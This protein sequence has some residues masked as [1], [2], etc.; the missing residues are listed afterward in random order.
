MFSS[1]NLLMK[2]DHGLMS[3]NPE[4]KTVIISLNRKFEDSVIHIFIFVGPSSLGG[5]QR[6]GVELDFK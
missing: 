5:Y 2:E 3:T 1:F 6:A 4:S